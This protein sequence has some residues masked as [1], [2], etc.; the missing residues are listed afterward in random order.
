[1]KDE[2]IYKFL[3]NSTVS[4]TYIPDFIDDNNIDFIWIW[5]CVCRAHRDVLTGRR[6]V[7]SY[8][9]II[10]EDEINLL[11]K[12]LYN[13]IIECYLSNCLVNPRTIIKILKQKYHSATIGQIQKLV[14]MTF[15]YMIVLKHFQI[16]KFVIIEED[17]CD[18]PLD[19][20]IL[21]KT[22]SFKDEHWTLLNDFGLYEDIQKEIEENKK[23]RNRL[24]FD[25]DNWE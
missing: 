23:Y 10:D 24:E 25:F 3:I 15:K 18:C 9:S 13:Y 5:R 16:V 22:K 11:V 19:S 8:S 2:Y 12:D 20:V 21:G 17:I 1:M 7:L 4:K 6:Y 14:N